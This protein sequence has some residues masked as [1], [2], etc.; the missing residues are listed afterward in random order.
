[1]RKNLFIGGASVASAC[2]LIG[3]GAAVSAG[4]M[5]PEEAFEEV[6]VGMVGFSTG[7]DEPI[8]CTFEGVE[9]PAAPVL[10]PEARAGVATGAVRVR[11][12]AGVGGQAHGDAP[13]TVI[14][15]TGTASASACG[16]G[17][18]PGDG[19]TFTVTNENGDVTEVDGDL[20]TPPPGAVFV[21]SDDVREGTAEECAAMRVEFEQLGT[22]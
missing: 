10:T 6:T 20:A 11:P 22:P 2:V 12:D 9:L 19:P 3:L 13:S 4:A 16:E 1:M 17:E 5:A 18:V 7:I 8:S 15:A 14:V 21:S